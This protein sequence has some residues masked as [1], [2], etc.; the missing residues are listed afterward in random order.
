MDAGGKKVYIEGIIDRMD[1]LPDGSIKIIDYKTGNDKFSESEARA[2]WKLQLMIYLMAGMGYG[3]I[4]RKPA[5]V[6]YFNIKDDVISQKKYLEELSPE[7]LMADFRLE[8]AMINDEDVIRAV[9]G[10]FEKESEVA[11]VSRKDDGG[12]T[13]YSRLISADDFNEFMREVADKV[14]ELATGITEGKISPD[15]AKKESGGL[16]ACT[17]C[18]YRS[19]CGFDTAFDGCKYRWI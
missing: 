12:Y 9:A 13:A 17:Y 7:K 19:F 5:G 11:K 10:D 18:D 2:G 3:G 14:T 15:P 16:S 4:D 1:V 8:G 6:F